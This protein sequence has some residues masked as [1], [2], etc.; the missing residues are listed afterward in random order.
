[1]AVLSSTLLLPFVDAIPNVWIN[2]LHYDNANADVGEFIE[3]AGEA[4]ADLSEFTLL[5]YTGNTG[6][7]YSTVPL[8]GI[9]ANT[10]NGY[11]FSVVNPPVAF[12][13]GA[14]DGLALVWSG[15]LAQFLSYEG[16]FAGA[17]GAAAGVVSLDIGV[18]ET[19]TTP[20]GHS[21]QLGGSGSYYQDFSWNAPAQSTPGEANQG[22][23][24]IA[25]VTAPPAPDQ[26]SAVPDTASTLFLFALAV[27][28]LLLGRPRRH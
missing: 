12:Q 23:S 6:T 16:S 13:N 10:T 24:F 17:A 1:M 19:T 25:R 21:L 11:G 28:A 9:L 15:V 5:L 18:A 26:G 7:V 4:G 22:Q 3:I 20:V 2:E 14:P 8:A 27:P